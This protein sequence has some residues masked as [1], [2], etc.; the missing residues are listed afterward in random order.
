MDT[1]A[2][3]D[4]SAAQDDAAPEATDRRTRHR[5]R[6]RNQVYEAAVALFVEQGFDNTTME[7]VSQRADV[8]RATVFNHYQKKTAF[9]DEW[10][11]RRRSRAFAAVR[12]ED[13]AD[14]SLERI[15]RRY[16]TESA[17]MS[18]ETRAETVAL[19]TATVHATD[20]LAHPVLADEL[21]PF[22][23]EAQKSGE[24]PAKM[25]PGQAALIIATSYFAV[26]TQWISEEPAP[27]D[28]KTELLAMLDIVLG[29]ILKRD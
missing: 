8:A 5:Q 12:E 27:F 19:M 11:S 6:R 20:L 18:E 14:W 26:L 10:M 25:N 29:G 16:L 24:A 23:V 2:G 1:S 21:A 22:I 28:L 13:V 17:R 9:L 15:L 7:Q 3:L 4:A